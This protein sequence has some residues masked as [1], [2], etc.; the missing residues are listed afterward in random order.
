MMVVMMEMVMMV[1]VMAAYLQRHDYG[2]AH[3]HTSYVNACNS[4]NS[5]GEI[6][7]ALK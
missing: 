3:K 4:P 2:Q 1:V 7:S 6:N 5:P